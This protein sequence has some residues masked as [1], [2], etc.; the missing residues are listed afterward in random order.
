M[1]WDFWAPVLG[2]ML[3]LVV[4]GGAIWLANKNKHGSRL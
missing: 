4:L 1:G 2:V 3:M